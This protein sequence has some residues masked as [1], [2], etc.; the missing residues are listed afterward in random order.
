MLI[1]FNHQEKV[2]ALSQLAFL[3]RSGGLLFIGHAD[4]SFIPNGFIKKSSRDGNYFI[5]T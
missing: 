5:K 3:L 2:K 4:I 1:Y